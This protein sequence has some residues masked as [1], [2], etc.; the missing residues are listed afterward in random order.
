MACENDEE[1]VEVMLQHGVNPNVKPVNRLPLNIA[2]RKGQEEVVKVLL[3]YGADVNGK[4]FFGSETSVPVLEACRNGFFSI[5]Q[6]LINSGAQLAFYGQNKYS[7]P[8]YLIC[9]HDSL[10]SLSLIIS[11]ITQEVKLD[12]FPT[13]E[14]SWGEMFRLA[15]WSSNI[16][17]ITAFVSLC[18]QEILPAMTWVP[19]KPL[20]QSAVS[21][22]FFILPFSFCS[23]F[24]FKF[25]VFFSFHFCIFAFCHFSVFHFFIF[26]FFHFFIFLYPFVGHE[27]LPTITWV[28]RIPLIRVQYL[29]IFSFFHFIFSYLN[30]LLHFF[31]FPFLH[32]IFSF[33]HFSFFYPFVA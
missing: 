22:H 6:L 31:I 17:C 7:H 26:S 29:F 1:I 19:R 27:I 15:I 20:N 16:K 23:F 25:F 10:E 32:F 14:Q 30:S 28:P 4:D 8:I 11:L 9:T 24:I 5:A 33:F 13:T 18:G 2:S 3:K 21:F 12:G